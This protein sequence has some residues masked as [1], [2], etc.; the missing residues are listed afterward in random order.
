VNIGPWVFGAIAVAAL[1]FEAMATGAVTVSN[2]ANAIAD[3]T[4]YQ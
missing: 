1:I 2:F 4:E 3:R